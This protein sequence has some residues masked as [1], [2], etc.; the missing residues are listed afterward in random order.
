[1]GEASLAA[2]ALNGHKRG[3]PTLVNGKPAYLTPGQWDIVWWIAEGKR[4]SEISQILEISRP[5]VKMNIYRALSR[6]GA[7]TRAG[8][9]AAVMRDPRLR[10][11]LAAVGKKQK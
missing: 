9:I 6:M 10:S 2:V 3:T 11:K 5:S 7:N 1:M 8:L 4:D